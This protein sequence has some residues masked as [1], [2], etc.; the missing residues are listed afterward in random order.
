MASD[1]ME[2]IEQVTENDN[3]N[4]IFI[5]AETE[6]EAGKLFNGL[7]EGGKVEMPI[8]CGPFGNYFGMFA[9]KFGIEWMVDFDS[10]LSPQKQSTKNNGPRPNE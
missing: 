7:S 3:R 5:S 2:I 6:A 1:V 4:T 8:S 9:D 10:K